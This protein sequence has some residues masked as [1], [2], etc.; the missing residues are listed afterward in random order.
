MDTYKVTYR[1]PQNLMPGYM[2]YY[3]NESSKSSDPNVRG[4]AN[5]LGRHA[6][7]LSGSTLVTDTPDS[8]R[9]CIDYHG[10]FALE[11]DIPAALRSI[12][13][14]RLSAIVRQALKRNS[15]QIQ[16]W[17]SR[18]LDGRTGN[19]V[20]LGLYRFEGV[21]V[22]HGEWID[23]SV[24]L[25]VIQSP[26]NLGFTNYGEGEDPTHWNYWK[27][28]LLAY[29][30][31]WLMGLPEGISG[32]LC[33][34]AVEMPGNI[35]GMWLEDIK[36]TYSGAWPLHRY[37]LTARHLGRL[38]G[39]YISRRDLPSFTWLSKQRIRQWLNSI[40]WQDF[41]WD[42]PQVWQQY[43]NPELDSFRSML[44]DNE[45][46]LAKLEQIPK[47]I[48][49]GETNPANFISRHSPRRQEQSVAMDWSL[50]GIEPLGSD[51]GQLVYGTYLNLKT[52]RLHDISET[53]FTSYIN[54]L[55]DS[56][57]RIDTQLVRFGYTA[58]AAFRVGLAKLVHLG[59]QLNREYEYIPQSSYPS[60]TP[61]PFESVMADEAYRLLD[62][63]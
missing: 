45:R 58:S 30:S 44:Q 51:L 29:Q 25:K 35:A 63:I 47:T 41:P 33:Y 8:M 55:Q 14:S 38:N 50:V 46:F 34:E 43:P 32:P 2:S 20:S 6:S 23:W 24:I 40:A 21:G 57:C 10:C 13:K 54:G 4:V 31:G 56:G 60:I 28:E 11:K 22:D 62:R 9:V 42:H 27:R 17:R 7:R 12:N 5:K 52:Y 19:P 18:N 16:G 53:L 59:E 1:R 26:A 48:C 15:F 61:Q 36:D 39:I 3:G 37:A 49:L